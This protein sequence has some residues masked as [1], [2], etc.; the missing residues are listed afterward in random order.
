AVGHGGVFVGE[1]PNL[2]FLEDTDGDDKADRRTVLLDGWGYQDTHE[3]LNSFIWGPDGWLY[4]CHAVFT[5]PPLANPR[6]PPHHRVPLTAG[7]WR[8]RPLTKKFEVFAEGTSNPWGFDFD[9]HGSGFLTACVI[10][11]L[12]H[13]VPGGLYRRQAGQN[14]NPYAY[15]EIKEICDHVH[16]F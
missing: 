10:P 6:T 9:E 2:I 13:M 3:T 7:I 15:G 4:A 12:F 8:Y 5:H 14:F 1:P 11:H 16:Y